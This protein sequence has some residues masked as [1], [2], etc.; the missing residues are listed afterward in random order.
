MELAAYDLLGRLADRAG[1]SET[2]LTA[3]MIEQE[4]RAMA[5]RLADFFERAVEASLRELDPD[6]IGKQLD[7][8]LADAHA[9]EQQSAKLLQKAPKLS[10]DAELGSA[11]Q[12]HL[13]ETRRHLELTE[14]RLQDRGDGPSGIKDAALRLGGA[15]PRHVPQGAEHHACEA[16]R[17]RIR[18]RAPGGGGV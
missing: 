14:R 6:D 5:D 8:Y 16:G 4:E 13:Q 9:I 10:G 7:K 18:V 11:L 1:D 15:E 17:V 2:A 12:D 3:R